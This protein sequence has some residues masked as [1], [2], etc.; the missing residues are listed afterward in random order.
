MIASVAFILSIAANS[1]CS[2]VD[3][4]EDNILRDPPTR[5]LALEALTTYESAFYSMPTS[6]TWLLTAGFTKKCFCVR[7]VEPGTHVTVFK[8]GGEKN[9]PPSR[10]P[11]W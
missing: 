7:C 11:P 1:Q 8:I 3:V 6:L 10:H 4:D 9:F 2:L 5:P